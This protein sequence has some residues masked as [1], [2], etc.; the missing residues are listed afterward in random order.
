MK[1]LPNKF[2][3]PLISLSLTLLPGT[4]CVPTPLENT[5]PANLQKRDSWNWNGSGNCNFI[6]ATACLAALYKFVPTLIYTKETKFSVLNAITAS[7]LAM[8]TCG[9]S[10]DYA[11]AA[12]WGISKGSVIVTKP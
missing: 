1:L 8:W 9:N 4:L 10:A 3:L 6:D 7:C 11:S 5:T 2:V 12:Q